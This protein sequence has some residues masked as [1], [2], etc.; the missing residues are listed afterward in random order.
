MEAG[1]DNIAALVE[2]AGNSALCAAAWGFTARAGLNL[3]QV[4]GISTPG[5]LPQQDQMDLTQFPGA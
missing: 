2:A 1:P 3:A 4:P 5:L